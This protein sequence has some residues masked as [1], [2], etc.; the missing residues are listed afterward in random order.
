MIFQLNLLVEFY[1]KEIDKLLQKGLIKPSKF[2]WSCTALYVNNAAE[3]ERR[4][5]LLGW[6]R[7]EAG[8]IIEEEDD[9]PQDHQDRH[10][11][12]HP[13]LQ[14]YKEEEWA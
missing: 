7:L 10:M 13:A 6:P 11:D 9:H 5:T 2:S 8:E 4:W 14:L 3:R 1:K 12:P